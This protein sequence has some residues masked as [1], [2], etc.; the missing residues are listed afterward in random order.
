MVAVASVLT[1]P[2]QEHVQL[3]SRIQFFS[4]WL[5]MKS[6]RKFDELY[7]DSLQENFSYIVDQCEQYDKLYQKK[8]SQTVPGS[9]RCS[10]TH[11]WPF[12]SLGTRLIICL[13]GVAFK[14]RDSSIRR[15]CLKLLA[16]ID[17][18]GVF[19]TQYLVSFVQAVV[20]FEEAR[21]R[22]SGF[23]EGTQDLLCH[24][25]S[26]KARLLNV[27][28]DRSVLAAVPEFYKA[29][30]GSFVYA[31]LGPG[32]KVEVRTRSFFIDRR[33]SERF[34]N[35]RIGWGS[36]KCKLERTTWQDL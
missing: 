23:V 11:S 32:N 13:C 7:T 16:S 9:T 21:A 19:D 26:S 6:W 24:Q 30:K 33:A 8:V 25:V 27:D 18:Q 4:L 17:L 2:E 12:H 28:L 22:V 15:R 29:N 14:C 5:E 10:S 1:E 35:T 31:V 34:V 3:L 20:D 36:T